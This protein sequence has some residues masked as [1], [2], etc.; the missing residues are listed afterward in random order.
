MDIVVQLGLVNHVNGVSL[1]DSLFFLWRV[2][3]KMTDIDKVYDSS[4]AKLFKLYQIPL[5]DLEYK[6]N[7]TNPVRVFDSDDNKIGYATVYTGQ[8]KYTYLYCDLFLN[9]NIPERL[10]IEL[11]KS[12]YVHVDPL[13]N[14]YSEQYVIHSVSLSTTV[15]PDSVPLTIPQ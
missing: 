9:Y 15:N 2:W 5:L 1:L 14:K 11:G 3:R 12:Y 13:Y 4:S 6:V 8:R 10:D 7:F